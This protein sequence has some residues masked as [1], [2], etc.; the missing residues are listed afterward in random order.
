MM[1][2]TKRQAD[3]LAAIERLTKRGVAPTYREI[4]S[5]L[6]L[7]STSGIARM[8]DA[9]AERGLVRR[10]PHRARALEL[11]TPHGERT[12]PEIADEIVR[13]AWEIK[14]ATGGV[15]QTQLR[16]VVLGVLQA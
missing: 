13:R 9:L 2:L 5:E 12:K 8:I 3:C 6:G 1:G 10:M 4:Q 11:R 14:A 7:A 16:E 15:N